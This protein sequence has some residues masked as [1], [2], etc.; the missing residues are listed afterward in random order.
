MKISVIMPVYNMERYLQ[1]AI[2]SILIQTYTDF[3]FIIINDESTDDGL[4]IIKSF[5]DKRIRLIQN[6]KNIGLIKTLNKGIDLAKGEYIARMDADDIAL[7]ERLQKQFNLLEIRPN[8]A[9][10]GSQATL[11]FN[12][13]LSYNR[14]NMETNPQLL[15]LMSL[16]FSPFLHPTVMIRTSILKE[17]QYDINFPIA[18]DYHLWTNLLKRQYIG[19]NL[20]ESLLLYRIHENNVSTV[21]Q[22]EKL[23]SIRKIYQLNLQTISLNYTP[24]ELY[25]YLKVSDAYSVSLTKIE[26]AEIK[27]WLIKIQQHLLTTKQFEKDIIE[28]VFGR[29][30]YRIHRKNSH[31]GLRIFYYYIFNRKDLILSIP[32]KRTVFF[33]VKCLIKQL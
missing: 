11:I 15:K 14:F 7:P 21:R 5:K 8:Y 10:V 29:V 30:W 1:E 27:N 32:I 33:F 6:E 2:R 16:F 24:N 4:K 22:Q 9:L 18:E 25:T 3:E 28:K 12:H 20:K 31:Q 17:F 23:E 19:T 13:R 26:F